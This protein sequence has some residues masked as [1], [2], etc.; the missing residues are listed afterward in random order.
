MSH[1][2][3]EK[4]WD[5]LEILRSQKRNNYISSKLDW[6]TYRKIYFDR[7]WWEIWNMRFHDNGWSWIHENCLGETR[8]LFKKFD[9]KFVKLSFP[10]KIL[11]TILK[12]FHK[13]W[14][15]IKTLLQPECETG[16][17]LFSKLRP[18]LTITLKSHLE[19]KRHDEGTEWSTY[20]NG[21]EA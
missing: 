9:E 14:M 16:E 11:F 5:T 17:S 4:I 1:T 13:L 2:V 20:G 15:I 3:W 10:A 21:N 12:S 19:F 6:S 8:W 18:S 7:R